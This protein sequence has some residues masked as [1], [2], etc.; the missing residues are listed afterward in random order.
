MTETR[1]TRVHRF[2]LYTRYEHLPEHLQ[3]YSRP[4]CEAARR[5][6]AMD[7]DTADAHIKGLFDTLWVDVPWDD[8][9]DVPEADAAAE[10]LRKARAQAVHP[11]MW[12]DRRHVARMVRTVI[13]AKD[14]FVRAC[15]P[16]PEETP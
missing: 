13:Q 2:D 7:G 4:F 10:L 3:G 12:R 5:L 16:E 6:W 8:A 1:T 15:L 11:A 9:V 14:A